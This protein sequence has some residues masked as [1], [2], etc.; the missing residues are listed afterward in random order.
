[1]SNNPFFKSKESKKSNNRF[2]CLY[3]DDNNDKKSS[4]KDSSSKSKKNIEY[5]STSNFFTQPPKLDMR[6]SFRNNNNNNNNDVNRRNNNF[7][8][9]P[10]EPSPLPQPNI[11]NNDELF[12]ELISIKSSTQ[13]SSKE[14]STKF[15]DILSNVIEDD[16]PKTNQ[17]PPGWVQI[18]MVNRQT[19]FNYGPQTQF[20]IRQTKK[21]E[22]NREQENEPN[23]IMNTVIAALKKNLERYEQEY[24]E[25]HCEGAYNERFR[26]PPVYGPEYDTESEE[27]YSEDDDF[28][29]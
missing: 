22:I 20:M 10:R 13:I 5:D 15:K 12:P 27:E 4:F 23:Y 1:M 19:V 18:T 17:I 14:A 29:E 6:E 7:K 2:Q 16:T 24:D 11:S 8:Y 3:D 28:S 25:I 26:L 21:E 9:K